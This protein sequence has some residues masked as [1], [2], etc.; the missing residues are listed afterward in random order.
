M[1]LNKLL[2]SG[3]LQRDVGFKVA[4]YK[5]RERVKKTVLL[6]GIELAADIEWRNLHD[7]ESCLA[8]AVDATKNWTLFCM[9]C[10]VKIKSIWIATFTD[11]LDKLSAVGLQLY[12]ELPR[13]IN[14]PDSFIDTRDMIHGSVYRWA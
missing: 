7:T 14:D 1:I 3:S 4:V 8:R 13:T 5:F 10:L 12:F 9:K 2:K 6:A 11:K